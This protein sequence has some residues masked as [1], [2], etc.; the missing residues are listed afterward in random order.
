MP[1]EDHR[2]AIRKYEEGQEQLKIR[3]PKGFKAQILAYVK[4]KAKE[5][6]DNPKYNDIYRT[7]HKESV[8]ALVLYLL[9]EEMGIEFRKRKEEPK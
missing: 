9:G 7:P 5:D 4:E 1:T 3:V 8:N 2:K 6:P